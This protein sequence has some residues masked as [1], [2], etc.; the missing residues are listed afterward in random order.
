MTDVHAMAIAL[1]TVKPSSWINIANIVEKERWIEHWAYAQEVNV[2][3]WRKGDAM[4][5]IRKGRTQTD[6]TN[7]LSEQLN[8][9]NRE[10]EYWSRT[11]TGCQT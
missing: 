9:L 1:L 4:G 3:R 5:K 11:N 8:C 6:C 2:N 10:C 7:P